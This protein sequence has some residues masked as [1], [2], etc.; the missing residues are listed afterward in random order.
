MYNNLIRKIKLEIEAKENKMPT[1]CRFDC[2]TTKRRQGK[3]TKRA[4]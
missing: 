3:R 4:Q 1:V 2:N